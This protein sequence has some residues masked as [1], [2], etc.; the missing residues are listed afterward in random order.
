MRLA[1]S[2]DEWQKKKEKKIESFQ[3]KLFI[4]QQKR[5]STILRKI[6]IVY[7]LTFIFALYLLIV[8]FL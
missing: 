3:M 5:D 1:I 4:Q 2:A 7:G 8:Y 6:D